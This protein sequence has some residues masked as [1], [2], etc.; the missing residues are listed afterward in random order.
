MANGVKR[1]MILMPTGSGKSLTI[2][3]IMSYQ[4]IRDTLGIKDD[5]P[6]NVLFIAHNHRL[7][8]QAERTFADSHNVNLI[9]QSVFSPVPQETIDMIDAIVL[10]ECQHESA[11]TMQ[12]QLEKLG[13]FP[14][15]GLTAEEFRSDG[16]LL[17]F[18]EIIVP[19]TREQAVLEGWLA[20]TSL[21]SVVD[22]GP[23]DKTQIVCDTIEQYGDRMGNTL[24]FVRTKKEI[25]AVT[26]FLIDQGYRAVGLI[27]QSPREINKILDDFS[28]GKIRYIVNANR[29]GEGID[30]KGCHSVFIGKQ[31]NSLQV[32]NQIIGR[33]SRPDSESNVWELINPLSANNIDS[34]VIIGTPQQH[35]LIHKQHGMWNELEF[36][37]TSNRE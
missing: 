18:E 15:I 26:E 33:C 37:Y 13:N 9:I 30:L 35:T 14:I 32:V 8:T 28:E 5:H 19:I 29:L 7:L 21:F 31:C 10:D 2:A 3:V 16:C 22:A 24:V 1:I 6:M 25:A 4:P 34:T 36:D 17:K 23:R 27:N 20:P 11:Y 12:M